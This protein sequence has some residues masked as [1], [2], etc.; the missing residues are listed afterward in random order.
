MWPVADVGCLR[1]M[2]QSSRREVEGSRGVTSSTGFRK[3]RWILEEVA[4][5]SLF[6][7]LRGTLP[8]LFIT[9]F[10]QISTFNIAESRR[11][12]CQ[13][14]EGGDAWHSRSDFNSSVRNFFGLCFASMAIHENES[15]TSTELPQEAWMRLVME[16][17]RDCV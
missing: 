9:V 8:R 11:D 3:M 16:V 5:E 6:D 13:E 2:F 4:Q 14:P 17:S 1:N 12:S 7:D 15:K 10:L